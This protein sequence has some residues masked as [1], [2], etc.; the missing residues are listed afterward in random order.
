MDI[1]T[2]RYTSRW[3]PNPV[4]QIVA[5]LAGEKV[6]SHTMNII[7]GLAYEAAMLKGCRAGVPL[8]EAMKG[9]A[10]YQDMYVPV[11]DIEAGIEWGK[12]QD[13]ADYDYGGA[14]GIPLLMSE[15]WNDES[16][17]W[18]SEFSFRQIWKAGTLMLDPAFY[19]RVTPAHMR[20][21]NYKK[22]PIVRLR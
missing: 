12:E 14:I 3:P 5:R 4:S 6:F 2:V 22:S 10:V 19:R 8:E 15:D 20:M 18:C 11:P 9:V 1:I 17:W 16:S 21:C 13:G 7:D